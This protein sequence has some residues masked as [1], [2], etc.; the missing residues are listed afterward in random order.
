VVTSAG[1]S[2]ALAERIGADVYDLEVVDAASLTPSMRRVVFGGDALAAF[3]YEPGQDLMFGI[4]DERGSE[5]RRRYTIRSF[6]AGATTIAVD[7]VLHGDG[8]GAKW[9]GDARTG[10]RLEAIGPRGK[11]TVDGD[12]SWHLFAGDESFLP[13][14]CAMA[15][16]L[17]DPARATIVVSVD[18]AADEV[19]GVALP[20]LRYVHRDGASAA[21]AGR[22]VEALAGVGL[23]DGEGRAY[24]AGELRVVNA[25]RASLLDR[26]LGASRIAAKSYWRAGVANASHGEPG[27]D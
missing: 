22:L 27:R 9:F 25:M 16:S 17:P 13:A 18:S 11:V 21:D 4:A 14:A 3:R 5:V 1:D 7:A 20:G 23:R 10:D 24:L 19:P 15:E 8:P 12:A 26:G 6:D 2:R